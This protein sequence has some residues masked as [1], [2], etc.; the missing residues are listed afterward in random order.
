MIF[1]RAIAHM[2]RLLSMPKYVM[3]IC[4]WYINGEAAEISINQLQS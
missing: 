2:Q 3:A 4:M 1:A